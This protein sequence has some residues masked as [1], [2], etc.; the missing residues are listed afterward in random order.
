MVPEHSKQSK[1]GDGHQA[2]LR[3]QVARWVHGDKAGPQLSQD[4]LSK[5]QGQGYM[6]QS[7]D[8]PVM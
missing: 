3:A 5:G 8:I 1:S 7:M 4:F 6:R 2:E